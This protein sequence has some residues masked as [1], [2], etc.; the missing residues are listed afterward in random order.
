MLRVV[1][2]AFLWLVSCQID[3]ARLLHGGGA[4]SSQPASFTPA[5]RQLQASGG[6]QLTVVHTYPAVGGN[7]ITVLTS[8]DTFGPWLYSP[9]TP[10]TLDGLTYAAPCWNVLATVASLP[11]GT[12]TWNSASSGNTTAVDV[13]AAPS[14]T[15][16]LYMWWNNVVYVSTNR[17][18]T[19]ASTGLTVNYNPNG[20]D[21]NTAWMAVDPGNPDIVY[22]VTPHGTFGPT[23]S[24]T[25]T[26]LVNTTGTSCASSCWTAVAG[27]PAPSVHNG[28]NVVF[29][30]TSSFSGGKTQ[31]IYAAIAGSSGVWQSTNGGTGF[32]QKNAGAPPASIFNMTVDKFGQLWAVTNADRTIYKDA[33]ST[34]TNVTPAGGG[35][36]CTNLISIFQD[37]NTGASIGN[38]QMLAIDNFG[39]L[40]A[41]L[42]N[43]ADSWVSRISCASTVTTYQ[44]VAPQAGWLNNT[45]QTNSGQTQ[46]AIGAAA[47]DATGKI[48]GGSGIDILTTPDP[49]VS[50]V[51]QT[52][53]QWSFDTLGLNQLV[54]NMVMSPPGSGPT[55]IVWDRG[56]FAM[57]NPDIP[58][59]TQYPNKSSSPNAIITGGWGLDY[60]PGTPATQ[61]A[62]IADF[63]SGTYTEIASSSNGGS[64]WTNA[65]GAPAAG[66]GD[67]GVIA[68]STTTNWCTV[69]G[70]SSSQD[71]I[72]SCTTNGGTSW[73]TGTF[74]GSPAA[75]LN[76][77][78]KL[79]TQPLASDRVTAGTFYVV[80]LNQKFFSSTNSGAN[81]A[82][83]G[84]TSANVDGL[85]G[86][87]SRLVA[88]P[89]LGSTS[90]AG[91]VFYMGDQAGHLWKST[92]GAASFASV[93]SSLDRL[94]A[95][96]FGAPKPGN[97]YPAIYALQ[98]NSGTAAQG[99]YSSV[100]AGSTWNLINTPASEQLYPGQVA[101]FPSWLNGDGDVYGRIYVTTKGSGPGYYIDTADACPWVNFS[102]IIPNQN[103]T[104]TVTLSAAHSGLV[105]VAGVQFQIDGV[106]VGTVQTGQSTYSVNLNASGQTVGSHTL[107]VVTSGNGCTGVGSTKSIPV[108]TN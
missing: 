59:S 69:P 37:P 48:W 81:W 61:V 14:N 55:A 76:T 21:K 32:T 92:N 43:G 65:T 54:G 13:V 97:G 87:I 63:I 60:V 62:L 73:A 77:N 85:P 3:E 58:A 2:A 68:A 6:G 99:Y 16:V 15:N 22:L 35:G 44:S 38:N 57:N 67:A 30:Q 47:I 12:I 25:G 108:T 45:Q 8:G 41:T 95:F 104:G 9:S 39:T 106:N 75:F 80:D 4:G 82:A 28:G 88:A 71:I 34:W 51:V 33:S 86:G 84:A 74:T 66:I 31:G 89:K 52:T 101:D 72:V 5:W 53:A 94:G 100:D 90:T 40:V 20:Q 11:A 83:T 27:F 36:P 96:G 17:G 70:N 56:V 24:S 26:L 78:N 98:V 103:L 102:N 50:G 93:N 7:P 10:C 64:T 29:D 105:P 1:L 79:N 49:I 46:L 91:H 19:W 23:D 18:A 107:S 42:N